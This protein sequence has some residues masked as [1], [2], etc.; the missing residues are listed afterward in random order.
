MKRVWTLDDLERVLLLNL[1][2]VFVWVGSLPV[3]L[4]LA[5]LR[6]VF[7]D[8]CIIRMGLKGLHELI[9]ADLC[10]IKTL[11]CSSNFSNLLTA[12]VHNER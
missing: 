1:L 11:L 7:T 10:G 9:F 6:W 12:I 2:V 3:H 5:S 8:S 4:L